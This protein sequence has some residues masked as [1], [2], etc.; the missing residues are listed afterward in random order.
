M[1]EVVARAK[2]LDAFSSAHDAQLAIVLRA[3]GAAWSI[4][5]LQQQAQAFGFVPGAVPGRLIR[6]SADAGAPPV[7]SLSY[8]P[9]AAYADD[10]NQATLRHVGL[11]FDVPQT[12]ASA[13]PFGAWRQAARDLA[14]ALEAEIV[15]DGGR[16][17][18]D[19][20]FE[21]IGSELGQ[22]YA[23]LQQRDLAA[24]TAAARRLFS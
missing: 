7:L 20:S 3:R 6:P 8:D 22:L 24:G 12:E 13:D 4:G 1:L 5:Y 17:L 23:A 9:Q 15:D 16:P 19:A 2:E 14:G 11:A 10:P 18:P 21:T